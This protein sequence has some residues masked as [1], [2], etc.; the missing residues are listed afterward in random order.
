MTNE[1]MLQHMTNEE[2]IRELRNSKGWPTLGNVAAD[3][4]EMLSRNNDSMLDLVANMS[5]ALYD[6]YLENRSL[7]KEIREINHA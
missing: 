2:I 4:I 5:N 7:E 1:E 3:R 6:C